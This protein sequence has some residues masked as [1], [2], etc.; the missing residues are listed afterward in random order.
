MIPG[1]HLTK[2]V[3]AVLLV[4]VV[5]AGALSLPLPAA[6]PLDGEVQWF[7]AAPT[8]N[9]G[10]AA[11]NRI[12]VIVR[13]AITSAILDELG[14]YGQVHG[15]LPSLRLVAMTLSGHNR[16]TLQSLPFVE[17]VSTDRQRYLT[18][19]GT[20]DRDMIDVVDVQ[21]SGLVADPDPREVSET[22][23][24]VHLAL[25]DTGLIA[26]WRDFLVES[27]VDP[28]LAQAFLGGGAVADNPVPSNEF[29]TS[30]PT[31]QWEKDTNSH[32]IATASHIIGFKIA[33]RVVDGAA[34]G[35][36]LFPIDVFP[37]GASF[38]WSSRIIAAF[39]Y[40][41]R[42]KG[43]GRIGPTVIS[44]S[45]GG[46]SPNN[47]E[48]AAIDRAIAAGIVVV[49]SAGNRGERGMSYPGAYPQTISAGAVGWT[50]QFRPGTPTAPNFGFWWNQDLG[51][52]PDPGSG[53]AEESEAFVA[54]FSS[55][56]MLA[57]GQQLD[58]LAPG[59]WTVA[60]GSHGPNAGY[61]FWAGTSFSAPLTAGVAALMLEKNPTLSQSQAESIL[62][63]TARPMN[64]NDSRA[65]V[66]SGFDGM[67]GTISWDT[68][69]NGAPC[70]PV[71]A[72]LLQADAALAAAP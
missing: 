68:N 3:R 2:P 10:P 36:T 56:A 64:A 59:Q 46:P 51:Y 8:G 12:M 52:D 11:S 49:I 71:G 25:I 29:H 63:T 15:W 69:C 4:L 58:V 62:K 70:D 61:F 55:R 22:G 14:E 65:G 44:M 72:G 30:N 9:S 37:N 35:V 41:T 47:L 7:V 39:D 53:P 32:G 28:S 26:N 5:L 67:V 27:R 50:K 40:V 57:Q 31:N 34:P 21:E 24:G 20:W 38:T 33:G 13:P 45:I 42:L 54:G 1:L 6:P 43:S 18:D 16:T 60:P 19:V 66:L 48:R 23:A 17:S